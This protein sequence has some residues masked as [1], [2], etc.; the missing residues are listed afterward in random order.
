MRHATLYVDESGSFA[1]RGR[2]GIR[3]VGGPLFPGKRQEHRGEL[4]DILEGALGW[5]PPPWHA[6]EFANVWTFLF[7]L[8]DERLK[9]LIPTHLRSAAQE[10]SSIRYDS[11]I[12]ARAR[13][14]KAFRRVA[15]ESRLLLQKAR[16][17]V[18]EAFHALHPGSVV[19]CVEHDMSGITN[20]Y[21][22]MLEAALC[23]GVLALASDVEPEEEALLHLCI[24]EGPAD[25]VI[26]V[27]VDK[28]RR[29]ADLFTQWKVGP[30]I[31]VGDIELRDAKWE[32][33]LVLADLV[34]YSLGPR[35]A[36]AKHVSIAEAQSHGRKAL[37]RRCQDLF[38]CR[39]D[40]VAVAPALSAHAI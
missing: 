10:L 33:G 6:V 22:P 14:T 20:R 28:V 1:G 24:A 38:A 31:G 23:G 37:R 4:Q 25:T 8:Q 34:D 16:R 3:L 7:L 30:K 11:K 17:A 19:H 40:P 36:I 5:L 35:S 13:A 15:K 26:G 21:L 32:P 39:A 2:Q 27:A 18:G 29:F 12:L 9:N